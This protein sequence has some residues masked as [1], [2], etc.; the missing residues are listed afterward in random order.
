MDS[1]ALIQ[2]TLRNELSGTTV[3]A[4]PQQMLA[5]AMRRKRAERGSTY[6]TMPR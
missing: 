1:D 4:S 2:Q 3:G 5:A 6:A